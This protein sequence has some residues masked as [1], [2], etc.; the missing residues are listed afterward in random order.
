MDVSNIAE[1]NTFLVLDAIRS[2]GEVT[3]GQLIR[4]LGLSG[5]SVSRIVSAAAVG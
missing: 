5:A 4:E 3:R 1:L 2:K